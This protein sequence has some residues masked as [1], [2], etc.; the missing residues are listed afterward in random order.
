GGDVTIRLSVHEDLHLFTVCGPYSPHVAREVEKLARRCRGNIG[1]QFLDDRARRPGAPPLVFDASV[2]RLLSAL[3]SQCEQRSDSF[4][5]CDPPP[6]LEDLLQLSGISD[7]YATVTRSGLR[8]APKPEPAPA[9]PPSIRSL[10]SRPNRSTHARK[11]TILGKTEPQPQP[12]PQTPEDAGRR[13]YQ[14]NTSLKRTAD[15][16]RG[17][18]S[19]ARCVERI[20]PAKPPVA[21]GYDFSFVYRSSEKVGGDFFDFIP[22]DHRNLGIVIGDVSGHGLDAALIMCL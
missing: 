8:S 11:E 5:L 18:D 3:K 13:L 16:E 6:K 17:L 21:P 22:L 7:R 15:L 12:R 10:A 2:L 19:A 9:R 1:L 20:L 14:L 4:F